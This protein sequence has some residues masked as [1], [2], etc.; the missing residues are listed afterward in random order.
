MHNP[1]MESSVITPE[2]VRTN[3]GGGS[4]LEEIIGKSREQVLRSLK[5][6]DN[7]DE[8]DSMIYGYGEEEMTP[9]KTP[10]TNLH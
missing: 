7:V 5:S 8:E 3:T 1:R 9:T 10:T 2:L 4:N 6:L